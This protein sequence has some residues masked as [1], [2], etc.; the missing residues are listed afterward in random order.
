MSTRSNPHLDTR[1]VGLIVPSM[2][3]TTE[4]EFAWMG[5]DCVSFYAT[6]IFMDVSTPEALRAMNAEI[7]TAVRHLISLRPH[8]VAYVCTSGS[9]VDGAGGTTALEAEIAAGVGCPVVST[10][11]LMLEAMSHLRIRR[12]AL[13]APYPVEV[14]QLERDYLAQ[15]GID[16]ASMVCLGKSG[17]EIRAIQPDDV[18]AAIRSA[19]AGDVQ[20]I[21]ASCTDLRALEVVAELENELGKPVLTSN[22]VTM[23]GILK[24]LN[25]RRKLHGFGQLLDS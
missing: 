14:S 19:D 21:F 11:R 1:R 18:A 17:A 4:P 2:N 13:V 8:L 15:N 5:P 24:A 20:G 25:L 12:C 3:T 10:S 22:Q 16:V 23:W 6:R 7:A 9:F